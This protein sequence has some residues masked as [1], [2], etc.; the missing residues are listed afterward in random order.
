MSLVSNSDPGDRTGHDPTCAVRILNPAQCSPKQIRTDLFSPLNDHLKD[1]FVAARRLG[2]GIH[3]Q[4]L[5]EFMF[6]LVDNLRNLREYRMSDLVSDG[7]SGVLEKGHIR[8]CA[9][10]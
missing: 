9:E 2:A 4:T 10:W 7:Q 1:H 3:N 5:C 6:D 8:Q